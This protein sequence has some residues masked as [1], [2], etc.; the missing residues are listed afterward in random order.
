MA[1]I[2][3]LPKEEPQPQAQKEHDPT[4]YT[5]LA[6]N[7]HFAYLEQTGLEAEWQLGPDD[8]EEEA[9]R[10]YLL[11]WWDTTKELCSEKEKLKKSDKPW[12]LW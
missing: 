10:H 9:K 3:W 7:A 2:H 5:W 4:E 8:P 11:Q 12:F 1:Q 6:V